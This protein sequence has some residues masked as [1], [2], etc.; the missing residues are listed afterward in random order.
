MKQ[1]KQLLYVVLVTITL[2]THAMLWQLFGGGPKNQTPTP[3]GQVQTT[4][5][6]PIQPSPGSPVNINVH[7]APTQITNTTSSAASTAQAE[8]QNT[9]DMQTK[10][11]AYLK[12][13]GEYTQ[14]VHAGLIS[15]KYY[16]A[17]A[18]ALGSYLYLSYVCIQGNRYLLDTTRWSSFKQELSL[19]EL[20]GLDNQTLTNDLLHALHGRYIVVKDPLNTLEPMATFLYEIEVERKK[21]QYYQRLYS[22]IKLAHLTAIVPAKA[23]LYDTIAA[24]LDR[25][26]FIK[27]VFV[28]WAC[29]TKLKKQVLQEPGA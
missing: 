19:Q 11:Q 8:N 26:A 10:L 23:V 20:C 17:A 16:M 25:L 3:V 15:Y 2:T 18:L 22:W 1:L 21:L 27:H 7:V 24:R 4:S 5:I 6:P 28:T 14:R 29:H 13:C 9:I 12:S